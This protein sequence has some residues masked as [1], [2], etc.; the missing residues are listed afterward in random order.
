MFTTFCKKKSNASLA[1]ALSLTVSLNRLTNALVRSINS[2]ARQIIDY[3]QLLEI[4]T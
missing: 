1:L 2:S 4:V 3:E